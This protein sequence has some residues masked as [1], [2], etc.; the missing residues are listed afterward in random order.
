MSMWKYL[1]RKVSKKEVDVVSEVVRGASGG[2]PGEKDAE[3]VVFVSEEEVRVGS[4]GVEGGGDRGVRQPPQAP[5]A[6][7]STSKQSE[8]VGW[9]G[10]RKAPVASTSKQSGSKR[11]LEDSDSTRP[12]TAK[13]RYKFNVEWLKRF[14]WLEFKGEAMHCKSCDRFNGDPLG[15]GPGGG[16]TNF[17]LSALQRHDEASG[18]KWAHVKATKHAERQQR[19]ATSSQLQDD[20]SSAPS[21]A[22]RALSALQAAQQ[23]KLELLFRN[24]HFIAKMSLPFTKFP[25]LVTLDEAKG[26]QV[27]ETYRTNK[28]CREFIHAIAEV[29]RRQCRHDLQKAHFVSVTCDGSTDSSRR[30]QE[31]IYVRYAIEGEV[32]VRLAAVKSLERGDAQHIMGAIDETMRGATGLE[33]EEWKRKLVG[34]ASDG[35]AVNLGCNEGVA[36]QLKRD[37]NTPDNLVIVHC[38]AHRLELAFKD[39]TGSVDYYGKIARHLKNLYDFY[40]RSP[41]NRSMLERAAE[42][43]DIPFLVP[44]R[45]GGTRWVA[46]TER[47]LSNMVRGMPALLHHLEQLSNPD[48]PERVSGDAKAKA[49][50]FLTLMKDKRFV[51]TTA[52]LQDLFRCLCKASTSLQESARG[53]AGAYGA[54]QELK[55]QIGRL[56]EKDGPC[57][58]TRKG[59][60]MVLFSYSLL[61]CSIFCGLLM[62]SNVFCVFLVF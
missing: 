6:V 19:Q 27:G 37:D 48:C 52:F 59:Y 35:A 24:A 29:E 21:D 55:K 51:L 9:G 8:T 26:L 17:K 50:G 23:A 28:K 49:T 46:H 57:L 32:N 18:H 39:M 25:H 5:V 41:L 33:S 3:D 12:N 10:K 45:V 54:V 22:E 30:E 16:S 60:V 56:G 42:A 44:T 4:G 43:V 1:Q 34:F 36:T 58:R 2:P 40:W 13:R 14:P 20:P 11:K 53:I 62:H 15:K 31:I 38:T 7:A 47:A 61:L